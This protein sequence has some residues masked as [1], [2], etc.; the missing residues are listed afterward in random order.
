MVKDEE[1]KTTNGMTAM[2]FVCQGDPS[3]SVLLNLGSLLSCGASH[4]ETS[5]SASLA[6]MLSPRIS[7]AL[8][9]E[10]ISQGSERHRLKTKSFGL[11]SHV[12]L[13]DDPVSMNALCALPHKLLL[14][15]AIH[16]SCS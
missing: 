9:S 1:N 13:K 14:L 7:G 2:R 12:V 6:R 11:L 5:R 15:H 4:E 10:H 3:L 16:L 8:V